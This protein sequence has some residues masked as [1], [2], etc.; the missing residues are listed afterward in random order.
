[1]G[2][3]KDIRIFSQELRKNATREEKH[4]WYDFLR[5]HPLQFRRQVPFGGYI[6]DF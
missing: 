2:V 4:L 1:M 5:E 6:V 3:E